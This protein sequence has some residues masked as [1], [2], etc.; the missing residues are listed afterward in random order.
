MD[1]LGDTEADI[2]WSDKSSPLTF[3]LPSFFFPQQEDDRVLKLVQKK[4]CA[5]GP[6]TGKMSEKSRNKVLSVPWQ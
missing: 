5:S 2:R 1:V 4:F 3:F 6:Y